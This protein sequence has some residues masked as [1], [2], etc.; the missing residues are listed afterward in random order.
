M[1][2]LIIASAIVCAAMLSQ[3]ASMNWGFASGEIVGPTDAYCDGDGFLNAPATAYLY[4]LGDDGKTWTQVA[5]AGQ[6]DDF[7]F[8]PVN[9][10]ESID[11]VK[12]VS[13]LSDPTQTFRMQLITDD[14]KYMVE[15]EGKALVYEIVGTTGST[16]VQYFVEANK[17]SATGD[18]QS[19]PE[20][21][22]GLLLLLGVAGLA[23]KRKR[24]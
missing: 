21:T 7:S 10:A 1:K 24:A 14:G 19:V 12:A 15:S 5:T 9:I 6:N 3:A 23:L 16:F 11:G 18:W 13:S 8:G 20:P 17:G 22:S 2:K 4:L